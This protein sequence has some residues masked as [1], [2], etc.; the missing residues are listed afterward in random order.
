MKRAAQHLWPWRLGRV[1]AALA[2]G[3]RL[4]PS[5]LVLG[6][7]A[8]VSYGA[9]TVVGAR[10]CIDVR[11]A[12]RV[13][14]GQRVWLAHD[15]EIETNGH[16]FVGDGTTV[17]RRGS[18]NG[19]VT[20][21]RGCILAPDVFIS[22]GTH[23][24]RSPPWLPIREQERLG[25]VEAQ[26]EVHVQDD[27]WIGAHV[28]VCPAVTIGRG[29]IVGA[30]A[31]VTTDV[32]PYSVVAGAPARKIGLRLDWQPPR[33]VDFGREEDRIFVLA[34]DPQTGAPGCGG[35]IDVALDAR[36]D[37]IVLDY[38]AA[39]TLDVCIGGEHLR[40]AAGRGRSVVMPQTLLTLG[41]RP[42]R[43]LRFVPSG[44][45]VVKLLAASVQ[46]S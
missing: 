30:N 14:L 9:G 43:G 18:L 27:C 33:R 38:E 35:S 40:L 15:T 6:S 2:R 36:A 11:G 10:V 42:V 7:Y 39:A 31:V 12:G 46:I 19:D 29:S 25:A 24:F 20:I 13:T 32:W 3:V 17:Q 5:A 26:G 37:R 44:T 4:H 34:G 23:P 1:A 16:L 28:V 22:S 21:G 8:A 45:T 41:G